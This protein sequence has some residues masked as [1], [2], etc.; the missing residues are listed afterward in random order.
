MDFGFL[1][2]RKNVKSAFETP[3]L[4]Q[5]LMVVGLGGLAF[6]LSEAFMKSFNLNYSV[7]IFIA[8]FLILAVFS[9][10]LFTFSVALGKKTEITKIISG[11]SFGWYYLIFSVIVI[12]IFSFA[13][14]LTPAGSTTKIAFDNGFTN[15]E[16]AELTLLMNEENQEGFANLVDSKSISAQDKAQLMSNF[17]ANKDALLL[18]I[19]VETIQL[20]S[21]LFVFLG[22]LAVP[23][24]IIKQIFKK[25]I[26]S[27]I[28]FWVVLWG[29]SI[30]I[31]A[32]I[33]T[34]YYSAFFSII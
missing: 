7:M 5:A 26:F 3:N 14:G 9:I 24:L 13:F 32:F 29:I 33:M 25:S 20:I 31:M 12:L 18:Y 2:L 10:C 21:L 15:G 6:I 8:Q 30:T 19:I 16:T 17:N 34:F 11:L 23:Y 22:F 28:I 1:K 4:M 27:S